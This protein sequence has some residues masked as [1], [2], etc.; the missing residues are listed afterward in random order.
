MS[1]LN[2]LLNKERI[3]TTKQP[4]KPGRRTMANRRRV[5]LKALL[6]DADLRR[7]LMVSTIQATQAREGIET[8]R[9][10]AERAYYVVTE[11]LA[12]AK[13]KIQRRRAPGQD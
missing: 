9:E 4:K 8:T 2:N 6:A 13:E 7:E 10:Q 5:N 3:L 1:R 11:A 12:L